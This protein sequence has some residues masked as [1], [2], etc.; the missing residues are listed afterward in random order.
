MIDIVILRLKILI[1]F[2]LNKTNYNLEQFGKKNIF[3]FLGADYGN[4]GDVA[5]TYA[6]IHFL[7]EQYPEYNVIEIPISQT[8]AGIRA[9]KRVIGKEDI[10]ALIGGGNT[11]DLYD[12]IEWLRQLV[13]LNFRHQR[14]VGFP[15]TF[16]FTNTLKG[17]FCK[18]IASIVYRQAGSLVILAREKNT[19]NILQQDFQH[20][21]V[22]LAP[23]IVMTLDKRQYR[24][25]AGMLVCLR[26]DKERSLTDEMKTQLIKK[27][28]GK[29]SH[30]S[31]Q[32]TQIDNVTTFNRFEKLENLIT[33]FSRHQL[34]VTDRLHG[35]ILC[36]ITGTP[37]LVF[38]NSNHKISA[39]FNWIKDCGFIK[40][41]DSI[42]DITEFTIADHFEESQSHILTLYNH[43][44][45]QL[46]R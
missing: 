9:V 31:Y 3:I 17:R 36:Y 11:S 16:D 19:L 2:F 32:D 18:K 4:L 23:D 6:Q 21:A 5:I 24:E 25:R 33:I 45:C 14:I 34:V 37:A 22:E 40:M 20:I 43:I 30:I 26:S 1:S 15:Q 8:A 12:D 41:C 10:I 35:M 46:F 42:D 28:Q 27:L 39:C 7:K 29:Y 44:L 38:D 13:I